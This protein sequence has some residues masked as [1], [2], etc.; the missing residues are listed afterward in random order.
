MAKAGDEAHDRRMAE[1][2]RSGDRRKDGDASQIPPD[3]DRRKKDRRE[4]QRRG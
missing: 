3:G 2:R 4:G 1:D